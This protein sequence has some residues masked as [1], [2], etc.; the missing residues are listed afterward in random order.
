MYELNGK[1]FQKKTPALEYAKNYI[2]GNIPYNKIID[3]ESDNGKF[4]LDLIAYHPNLD[5]KQGFFH[6]DLVHEPLERGV[7][8][9]VAGA[10]QGF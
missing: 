9:V 5:E 7:C 1:T 6:T 10:L 8:F 4:L 2:N 3:L